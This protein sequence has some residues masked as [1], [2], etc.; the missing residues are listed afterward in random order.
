MN[1]EPDNNNFI[2]NTLPGD[3]LQNEIDN[4][5][6]TDY[7]ILYEKYVYYWAKVLSIND[8]TGVLV[9]ETYSKNPHKFECHKSNIMAVCEEA[10]IMEV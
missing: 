1:Y 2:I 8:N 4:L 5:K 3:K 10:Y 6:C 9:C 7:I